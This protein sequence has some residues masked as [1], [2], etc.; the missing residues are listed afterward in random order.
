MTEQPEYRW[1]DLA[2]LRGHPM[3]SNVMSEEAMATLRRHIEQSNRY[4]PL[5]VRSLPDEPGAYQ[6]LDG[7]HRW[8]VLEA[9]GHE[10]A[11]CMVWAADDDQAMLLLATLNRLEGDD[12]P[13]RRSAL[14]RELHERLGGSLGSLGRMLPDAPRDLK[15]LLTLDRPLPTPADAKPLERMHRSIHFFLAPED[16]RKVERT[17]ERIG[18]TREQA[19]MTL[20]ARAADAP[21]SGAVAEGSE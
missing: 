2:A 17:L 18:P 19:L 20:I 10:Q 4:P 5:I 8:R 15:K 12:D 3:N 13:H 14:I 11:A 21:N 7:H 6:V 1:I 9:L 16:C